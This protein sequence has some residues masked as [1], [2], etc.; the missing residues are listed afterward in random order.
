MTFTKEQ[1]TILA[2]YE[3]FFDDALDRKVVRNCGDRAANA[4]GEIWHTATN[5]RLKKYTCAQCRYNLLRQV[6]MAYR[7]DIAELLEKQKVEQKSTP[8]TK[9]RKAK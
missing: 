6:G 2:Q 3:H 1:I 7:R 5:T 8:T 4:I 9:K